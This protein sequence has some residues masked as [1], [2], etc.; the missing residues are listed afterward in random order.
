MRRMVVLM[1][2]ARML[3]ILVGIREEL[4]GV[5][6]MGYNYNEKGHCARV[7]PKPR[8]RDSN[9]FKE[10]MLLAKKYEA[11][12]DLNDEENEFL[13]ADIPDE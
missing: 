12:I 9:Y 7:C 2:K 8:V 11:G 5:L 6:L 3:E 13:L 4:L 1:F 10:H